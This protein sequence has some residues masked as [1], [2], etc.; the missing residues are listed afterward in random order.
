MSYNWENKRHYVLFVVF[1]IN[2]KCMHQSLRNAFPS[3][4]LISPKAKGQ[5]A[6]NFLQPKRLWLRP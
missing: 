1:Y 2:V 5:T 4:V 3:I 6:R